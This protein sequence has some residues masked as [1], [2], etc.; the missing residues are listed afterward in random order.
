MAQLQQHVYNKT[1][2]TSHLFQEL[3]AAVL[4]EALVVVCDGLHNGA[5]VK[6]NGTLSV[7]KMRKKVVNRKLLVDRAALRF[8]FHIM[9]G[10]TYLMLHES[11]HSLM[12]S[13]LD[14]GMA[15]TWK[16]CFSRGK[17][18]Q[19]GKVRPSLRA[20][21]F[22]LAA[23]T[24]LLRP[25]DMI[26]VSLSSASVSRHL[27]PN[28][29]HLALVV[30][31]DKNQVKVAVHVSGTFKV[32]AFNFAQCQHKGGLNEATEATGRET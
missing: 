1:S 22:E 3:P 16:G 12:S 24:A 14:I 10:M 5:P 9:Q 18:G 20:R 21:A 31:E 17:V 27:G 32:G 23:S 2:P 4:Q 30:A 7:P 25:P 8:G 6:V 28:F 13:C 15:P 11:S 19:L 29:A 26:P